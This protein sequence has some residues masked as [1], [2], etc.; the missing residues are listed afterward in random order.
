MSS[1][2]ISYTSHYKPGGTALIAAGSITGRIIAT[3]KTR[4]AARNS[5]ICT[6]P[7]KLWGFRCS[8]PVLTTLSLQYAPVKIQEPSKVDPTSL[9]YLSPYLARNN[10]GC[11]KSPSTNFKA[12]LQH[13]AFIVMRLS[14][15]TSSQLKVHNDI[16]VRVFF[17][18]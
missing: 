3:F 12:S 14:S 18:V 16:T 11:Y 13:I 17:R 5:Q 7:C 2:A 10:L 6:S 1:S 4:W 9:K 15:K 8:A